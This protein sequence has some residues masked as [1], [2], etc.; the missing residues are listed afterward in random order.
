VVADAPRGSLLILDLFLEKQTDFRAAGRHHCLAHTVGRV[1][2]GNCG[3]NSF[4][5]SPISAKSAFTAPL[6]S[7][8]ELGRALIFVVQQDCEAI[9]LGR[10]RT[11]LSLQSRECR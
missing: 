6:G 3:T 8:S 1:V 5:G 11:T 4:G 2:P 10:C 7:E 9:D